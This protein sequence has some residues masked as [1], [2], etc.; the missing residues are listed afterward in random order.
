MDYEKVK[1]LNKLRD[2]LQTTEGTD[3]WVRIVVTDE[4]V[5]YCGAKTIEAQP[6]YYFCEEAIGDDVVPS[7][8]FFLRSGE[9]KSL[10]GQWIESYEVIDEQEGQ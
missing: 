4:M 9:I 8:A 1:A 6:E 3:K 5:E 2:I 7:I 10:A